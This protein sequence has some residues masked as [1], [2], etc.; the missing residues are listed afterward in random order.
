MKKIIFLMIAIIAVFAISGCTKEQPAAFA[1]GTDGL[2]V[3][4]IN[5]PTSVFTSSVFDINILLQNKGEAD[6]PLGKAVLTLNNAQTLGITNAI[7]T[8]TKL[9][10]RVRKIV[11]TTIPGETES[12]AWQNASFKGIIITEQQ[13]PPFSIDACYPYETTAIATACAGKTSD[14]C[15]PVEEKTVQSSGAP[16]QVTKFSQIA[17][18]K[19]SGVELA[20]TIDVENQGKGSVYDSAAVCSYNLSAIDLRPEQID[21]IVVNS[22][23]FN[24]IAINPLTACPLDRGRPIISLSDKKGLITC[25]FDVAVTQDFS[26]ELVVKLG[27]IYKDSLN[28]AIT[29]I[30]V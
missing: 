30:P 21:T 4:F 13:A 20:F 19:T 24:N 1:G 18:P 16:I 12:L 26:A 7:K 6:V 10:T 5:L 3:S 25:N 9:L 22:I 29:V 27:Y 23:T 2:A 11:N 28:G 15:K 17:V 14:V 8:N